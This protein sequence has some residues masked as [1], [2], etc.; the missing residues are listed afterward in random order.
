M[1]EVS[2]QDGKS[3]ER[4]ITVGQLAAVVAG[5]VAIF[6]AVTIL[7]TFVSNECQRGDPFMPQVFV[8]FPAK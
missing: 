5:I 4:L 8:C 1:T 3:R 7:L 2:N 6:L